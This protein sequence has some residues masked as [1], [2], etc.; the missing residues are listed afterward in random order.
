LSKLS[1]LNPSFLKLKQNKAFIDAEKFEEFNISPL[2]DFVS[3]D[4]CFKNSTNIQYH[5]KVQKPLLAQHI[6]QIILLYSLHKDIRNRISDHVDMWGR[7][8]FHSK[9]TQFVSD[10][11]T[12]WDA[13]L[14]RP[15][16][17]VKF[18]LKPWGFIRVF[19]IHFELHF[20]KSQFFSLFCGI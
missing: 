2:E 19:R 6:I 17:L 15:H 7:V 1:F 16:E 18:Q 4:I 20:L 11:Q 5:L 13:D 10:W 14:T 3:S 8:T 12:V 9:S